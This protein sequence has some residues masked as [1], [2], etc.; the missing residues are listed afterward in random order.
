[1][2]LKMWIPLPGSDEPPCVT[3]LDWTAFPS[4]SPAG[5]AHQMARIHVVEGPFVV[6]IVAAALRL[7]HGQQQLRALFL[8]I[9]HC[10]V[11]LY[12]VCDKCGSKCFENISMWLISGVCVTYGISTMCAHCWMRSKCGTQSLWSYE[13]GRSEAHIFPVSF[14]TK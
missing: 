10:L 13:W 12:R 9:S 4:G 1:M 3:T 7:H 14:A 5:H 11:I 8:V 2:K 6:L